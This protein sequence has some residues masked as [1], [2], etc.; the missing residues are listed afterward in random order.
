MFLKILFVYLRE[1]VSKTE[2]E[3]VERGEEE[4]A[5]SLWSRGPATGLDPRTLGSCSEPKADT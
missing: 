1:R 4:E 2:R 3:Q 5:D